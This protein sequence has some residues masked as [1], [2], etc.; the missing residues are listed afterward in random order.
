MAVA[1]ETKP[2]VLL[3]TDLETPRKANVLVI[4][5][6]ALVLK[7]LEKT[8]TDPRFELLSASSG[9]QALEVIRRIPLTVIICDQR[10]PDISGSEVLRHA[11]DLQKY[12]IRILLTGSG[13]LNDVVQAINIGQASQ[14]ILKPWDDTSLLQ[15]VCSYI[16]KSRLLQENERLQ[17]LT[18]EQ[19]IALTKAHDNI[20][21][22]LKL[23]A[24]IHEVML[25][26]HVPTDLPGLKVAASTA[27][28]KEIDGDF[29]DFF[30]PLPQLFDVVIGDV[31]GKGIPAALVGTAMK[32]QLTR[33]AVPFNRLQVFD[34][35]GIW[36]DD[37]YSPEEILTKVH[38]EL[39]P[40]LIELEYFA[41]L[42][43]G[44]FDL[45]Q[46]TLT[47]VDCG[48]SKPLHY[49]TK[50]GYAEEI[51]GDNFPVGVLPEETFTA[52]MTRFEKGDVFVFYSDGATEARAPSGELFG[53][54]RLKNLL[55]K[56][57]DCSPDQLLT[58]IKDAI[59]AFAGKAQFD[60]DLTV[61]IVH[62]ENTLLT[63]FSKEMAAKFHCDLSQIRAVRDFV[64]RLCL[65][66]PGDR[67]R[68]NEELQLAINEAFCNIV[69]HGYR[70][71]K[72][73]II[74]RGE[75]QDEGIVLELSDQGT[76]FDPSEVADPNFT[77]DRPNGFGWYIVK[78]IAD[79][80]I[81]ARKESDKG[82]N[83][84]KI[85]KK[86]R[87]EEGTMEISHDTRDG[88][89]IVTLEGEHLDARETPFFKQKVVDLLENESISRAI[90][91]LHRLQFI[92]SS[93]LGAF[94]SILKS[95][96][97]KGGDLKLAGMNRTIRTMFELV[98][99]HKIFEIFNSP[100][101]ALR[102]FQAPKA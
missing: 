96:H 2:G 27:P 53:V 8:L 85:Y 79:K 14:F 48:S 6:D 78:E 88:I 92:D 30:R 40:P 66:A 62:I 13:D 72:G 1:T 75:L 95:L 4:D 44:R 70:N 16:E 15:L 51:K 36:R 12:A 86:Y 74:L 33:F 82:W 61:I 56:H 21:R 58:I 77:G 37:V 32:T 87:L 68:L 47:Y 71:S 101:E 94:L 69:S 100:E 22:E 17:R 102:S 73:E 67:E 19:N 89:L 28:S 84:L 90:F 80:V 52:K 10:L 54:E 60:D 20:T 5:D 49:R 50:L 76:V 7:A 41:S 34:K 97:G 31:M 45:K 3:D 39:A 59:I 64:Q 99:M 26:G 23:G 93:G 43:Y 81:Y 98:C 63:Q 38:Q 9:A 57:H 55:E 83:H 29:Y 35:H 65:Q 91:D 11:I 18:N 42:F 25:L 24:R 46:A